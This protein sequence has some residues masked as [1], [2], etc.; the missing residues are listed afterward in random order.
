M[1][2]EDK[3]VRLARQ[4]KHEDNGWHTFEAK[5]IEERGRW[6][7]KTMGTDAWDC[8]T[9]G[10]E[11]VRMRT[12]RWHFKTMKDREVKVSDN[13]GKILRQWWTDSSETVRL[14]NHVAAFRENTTQPTSTSCPSGHCIWSCGRWQRERKVSMT[15]C[16]GWLIYKWE[17]YLILWIWGC[18]GAGVSDN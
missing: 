6:D 18:W 14:I 3:Q 1:T 16:S 10:T 2:M 4:V 13:G 8:K 17:I 5:T 9:M 12:D 15:S 11:T 7:F